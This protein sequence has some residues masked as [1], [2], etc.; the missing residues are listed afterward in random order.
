MEFQGPLLCFHMLTVPAWTRLAL[1]SLLH[2]GT[3]ERPFRQIQWKQKAEDYIRVEHEQ[4][5]RF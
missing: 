1:H 4:E 3:M 5:N 2:I